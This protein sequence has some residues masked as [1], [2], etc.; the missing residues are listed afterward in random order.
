[1]SRRK[2][3]KMRERKC[4]WSKIRKHITD[5]VKTRKSGRLRAAAPPVLS[6]SCHMS[7]K[8]CRN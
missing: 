4:H 8:K 1:M 5:E 2:K 7:Q 3:E 6:V